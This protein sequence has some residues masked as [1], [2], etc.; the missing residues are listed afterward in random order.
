MGITQLH[1]AEKR[2]LN[3]LLLMS[4]P[5]LHVLYDRGTSSLRSSCEVLWW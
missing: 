4:N 3:V 2:M 1:L 5:S